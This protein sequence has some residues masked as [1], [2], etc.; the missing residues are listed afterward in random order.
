[1]LTARICKAISIDPGVKYN[2]LRV[3]KEL[4]MALTRLSFPR[5]EAHFSRVVPDEKKIKKKKNC[6]YGNEGYTLNTHAH[7]PFSSGISLKK[8]R[9]TL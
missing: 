9:K 6:I 8:H 2:D 4:A 3:S 5:L 1:L 7:V